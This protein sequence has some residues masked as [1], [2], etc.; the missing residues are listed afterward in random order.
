MSV[1]TLNPLISR[2]HAPADLRDLPAWLCWRFETVPG[3]TKARKVPIYADGSKRR[4]RQGSTEDRARLVNYEAAFAAAMKR[5]WGVGFCPMPEFGITALDFDG[6]VD[7]GRIHPEV[8]SLV[9]GTYAE[10]SPSGRGVRAFVRGDLGNRKDAHGT[11]FGFEVFASKGFVTV[12]GAALEITKLTEA[13]DIVAEASPDVLELCAKRFG[14]VASEAPAPTDG[15]VP[16]LG[17]TLDQLRDA[18]DVL[19]DDLPYE[20]KESW[21]S[22][23][24][25]L[26]HE[27]GGSDEGFALWDDWS[28]R[29]PKYTTT[30]YGRFKWDS[31]ARGGQRPTTAHALVNMANANGARIDLAALQAGDDFEVLPDTPETIAA[32]KAKADKFKVIDATEFANRP[33]PGW[34]V[35]DVLP[36][37]ELVVLF[38]ESTAGKSFIALDMVE[39]IARGLPWRGKRVKQGRVA[40]VVAEGGGGFS[41]RLKAYEIENRVDHVG[42]PLGIIHAA[43]NLIEQGDAVEVC[44]QIVA[45]GG[46]DVVVVDTFAKTMVGGNENAGEDV[47]RALANCSGIH[48]ATG[49]VV[50]LVHHAGKDATKGARGWSGLKAAADAEIEVVRGPTGR[51]MR[52]SKQKDGEDGMA[53]GFD[54]KSVPVALNEDGDV[55]TS[56]VV[57]EAE[58]PAAGQVGEALK[59]A[60]PVSRAVIAVMSEIAESQTSGIELK[61][62]IEEAAKRLPEPDDG[63]R[64]T[65]KQRCR[66]ALLELC[67]GDSAPYFLEG[68]SLSIV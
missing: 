35:R 40:Y 7:A 41:K 12:T 22:V 15:D 63:K 49:A 6:C 13:E 8:Q 54:L 1:P 62:V 34:I 52:T 10:L 48:R 42:V 65:R 66:R 43:P 47:G 38:G 29:S 51:A 50:I 57:V 25:A 28:S 56:C 27:T 26:H 11:P 23:G 55:E 4:G 58:L 19:P 61:A 3:E 32:T 20:G 39:A 21:L 44:K 30:E 18:L 60:G 24:M 37:A 14:R 33:L 64:D 46:A 36:K 53:W 45:W 9:A 16:P 2:R 17:L 59:R 5:G 31:F 68:D 67:E